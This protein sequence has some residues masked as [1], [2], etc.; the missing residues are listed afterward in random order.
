MAYLFRN[1]YNRVAPVPRPCSEILS[2]CLNDV[3]CMDIGE[4]YFANCRNVASCV[5][6]CR[7]AVSGMIYNPIGATL[8]NCFCDGADDDDESECRQNRNT[9]LSCGFDPLVPPPGGSG[10]L[11]ISSAIFVT[12]LL[13]VCLLV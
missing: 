13:I 10:S 5:E 11:G 9:T 7:T 8:V 4:K 3:T 1:C 12:V 6:P 2:F